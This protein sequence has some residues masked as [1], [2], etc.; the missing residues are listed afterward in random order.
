MHQTLVVALRWRGTRHLP[1]KLREPLGSGG[2]LNCVV[3]EAVELAPPAVVDAA[4]S[5]DEVYRREFPAL[6]RYC[7]RL[8]GDEHAA[9]DVAQEAFVRLYARFVKVREPK[10]WLY[11]VATNIVRDRWKQQARRD[12]ATALLRPA[13]EAGPGPDLTVRDAVDRLPARLRS[14]VLLHYY[15]D[16]R[17]EDTA[18]ATGLPAGTVKRR[19]H[20][21]R[22]VLARTLGEPDD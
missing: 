20:E 9:R 14:I 18:A 7:L 21:A 10:P 11:L 3:M 19:L 5:F 2:S 1:R 8:I 6:G 12:R 16:L 17:I 22:T 4:W 15:A 13:P